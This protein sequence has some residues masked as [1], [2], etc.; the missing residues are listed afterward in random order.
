MHVG[1]LFIAFA[2]SETHAGASVRDRLSAHNKKGWRTP[3]RSTARESNGGDVDGL[4]ELAGE[5]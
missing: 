5:M 1:S 4:T 2:A 3:T